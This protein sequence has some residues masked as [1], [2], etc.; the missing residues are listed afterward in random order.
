VKAYSPEGRIVWSFP[1]TETVE[2]ARGLD[3]LGSNEERRE[4]AEE[5]PFELPQG[6]TVDDA[7]RIVLVDAFRPRI[8]ALDPANGEVLGVY[9]RDG[10]LDGQFKYP[11]AIAYDSARDQYVV[12]DTGNH[13]LQIVRIEGSGGSVAAVAR[14]LEGQPLWVCCFPL[15]LLLILVAMAVAR[16]RREAAERVARDDDGTQGELAASRG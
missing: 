11:T 12:A 2:A 7:G 8:S 9:G 13:R 14:R 5:L 3:Q 4:L 16:S 15:A 6:M 1:D 10:A